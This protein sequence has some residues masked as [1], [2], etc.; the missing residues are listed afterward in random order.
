[1]SKSTVTLEVDVDLDELQQLVQIDWTE[2]ED[3]IAKGTVE[4]NLEEVFTETVTG[5]MLT[6]ASVPEPVP[7]AI[8]FAVADPIWKKNLEELNK[9]EDDEMVPFETSE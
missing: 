5:A 7:H 6:G 8:E 9:K 3:G 4:T 1:M 2:V